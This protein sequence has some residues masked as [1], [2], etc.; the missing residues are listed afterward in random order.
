MVYTKTE[1]EDCVPA[2]RHK[3][4]S[5]FKALLPAIEQEAARLMY[6]LV[7][8]Y[9]A[10]Q[11]ADGT[12]SAAADRIATAVRRA[13]Y[14]QAFADGIPQL[15]VVLTNT[16]LGVVST[17]D[18][19]P[20][21]RERVQALER[22]VHHDALI[23]R[24]DLL[25][26]CFASQ[27]WADDQLEWMTTLTLFYHPAMVERFAGYKGKVSPETWQSMLPVIDGVSDWVADRIG[28]SQMEDLI[29]AMATPGTPSDEYRHLT[30]LIR[31]FIGVVIANA[32]PPETLPTGGA[33]AHPHWERLQ[34]WRNIQ[35]YL[36]GNIEAFPLY[37]DSD[38]Y[39]I[40]H[41]PRYDNEADSPAFHFVG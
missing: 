2:A 19:A 8:Q 32:A 36:D 41:P 33:A 7:G 29:R 4:D 40:N 10:E 35:N 5:V 34:Q 13:A 22:A 37:A 16:G 15:D 31:R 20:A 21:S 12:P 23:A 38:A 3:D 6:D 27:G 26:V 11:I 28:T 25:R 39:A 14:L 30:M 1:F 9:F 24:G 18:T 17:N